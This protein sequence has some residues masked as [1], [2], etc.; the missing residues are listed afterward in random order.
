[1]TTVRALIATAVKKHWNIYQ[2]DVNNVFLHEEL[3]EEVYMD[4]PQG[5]DVTTKGMVCKLNKSLHG[6]NR[7][8]DNGMLSC[9]M[10]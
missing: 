6:L 8:A 9:L 1:M 5:L 4:I 7:Q 2:L 3:R 10:L